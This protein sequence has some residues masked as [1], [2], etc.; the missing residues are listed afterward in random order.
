MKINLNHL[1]NQQIFG[2]GQFLIARQ[3]KNNS[4]VTLIASKS[5]FQKLIN[6]IFGNQL[7]KVSK[8]LNTPEGQKALTE[9]KNVQVVQNLNRLN[10]KIRSINMRLPCGKIAPIH[11]PK[12]E[13]IVKSIMNDPKISKNAKDL[14]QLLFID[15]VH[16][17]NIQKV[18]PLGTQLELLEERL[19]AFNQIHETKLGCLKTFHSDRLDPWQTIKITDP[20]IT[21]VGQISPLLNELNQI[22]FEKYGIQSNGGDD[23]I[24]IDGKQKNTPQCFQNKEG[25]IIYPQL[26]LSL[27]DFKRVLGIIPDKTAYI[28]ALKNAY[29]GIIS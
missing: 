21:T 27:I 17:E 2:S 19:K 11:I 12:I 23:S 3:N 5:K 24:V 25:E 7:R 4:T 14:F 29:H 1:A 13:P 18:Q 28:Q 9:G 10:E 8:I 20:T 15:L 6:D 22:L 16:S 26:L